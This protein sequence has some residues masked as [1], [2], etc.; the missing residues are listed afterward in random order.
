MM[1]EESKKSLRKVRLGL[2][3]VD[4][5]VIEVISVKK[6]EGMKMSAGKWK[7]MVRKVQAQKVGSGV[8]QT[9]YL[10]VCENK[11]SL[12]QIEE[13]KGKTKEEMI[14]KKVKWTEKENCKNKEQMRVASLE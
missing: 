12:Q 9:K 10:R 8:D 5:N 4:Q 2:Q 1:I 13:G 3:E 6:G 7:R 14:C 11:R